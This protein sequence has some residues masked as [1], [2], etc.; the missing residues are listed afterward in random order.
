MVGTDSSYLVDMLM[1][2]VHQYKGKKKQRDQYNCGKQGGKK[3]KNR[4]I[5]EAMKG[6]IAADD[7]EF[8]FDNK[9][10]LWLFG[11]LY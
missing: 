7:I 2:Q 5:R 11:F 1:D 4:Q 8:G 9:I 6:F 3:K 10:P